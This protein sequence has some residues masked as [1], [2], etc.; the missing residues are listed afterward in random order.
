MTT[1][2]EFEAKMR[3]SMRQ[4]IDGLSD[5]GAGDRL[6]A[7]TLARS[8]ADTIPAYSLAVWLDRSQRILRIAGEEL[9]K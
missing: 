1:D 7:G 9:G 8:L 6:I 4:L 2:D 5:N 3:E